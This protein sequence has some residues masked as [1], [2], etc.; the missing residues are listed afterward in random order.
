MAKQTK[1]KEE[2]PVEQPKVE[3]KNSYIEPTLNFEGH[4]NEFIT[5]VKSDSPELT[6]VGYAR[7]LL[8]FL[9]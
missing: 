6:A 2:T 7:V 5:H 4:N 8:G 9:L 1:T 3:S